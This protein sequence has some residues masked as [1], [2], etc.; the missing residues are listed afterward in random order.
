MK[1]SIDK[2]FKPARPWPL[3]RW[4]DVILIAVVR[5]RKVGFLVIWRKRQPVWTNRSTH[6]SWAGERI[7]ADNEL[8]Q[9]EEIHRQGSPIIVEPLSFCGPAV[10]PRVAIAGVFELA[11]HIFIF[12]LKLLVDTEQVE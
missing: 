9:K 11:A 10:V 4:Y 7:P 5:A 1:V 8:V 6:S 12:L 2:R 3:V